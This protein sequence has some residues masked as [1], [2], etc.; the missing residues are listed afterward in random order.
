M[1]DEVLNPGPRFSF[2]AGV[3]IPDAFCEPAEPASALIPNFSPRRSSKSSS[4]RPFD[5]K[6][7]ISRLRGILVRV[8]CR[9]FRAYLYDRST[10]RAGKEFNGKL[11]KSTLVAIERL[12]RNAHESIHDGKLLPGVSLQILQRL[13]H[14]SL[15]ASQMCA[16][17][18]R[19]AH[20][21]R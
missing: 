17:T 9:D 4:S 11:V 1:L 15:W 14:F 2:G 8:P 13:L 10:G 3:E 20:S 19:L 21:R 6:T 5:G 18:E 12:L 16:H 7:L